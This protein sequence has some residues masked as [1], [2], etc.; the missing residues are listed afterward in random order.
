MNALV[1]LRRRD[2][3]ATVVIGLYVYHVGA[4]KE[5]RVQSKVWRRDAQRMHQRSKYQ[6]TKFSTMLSMI[7]VMVVLTSIKVKSPRELRLMVM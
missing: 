3:I 4:V 7:V 5:V 2:T 1:A 6:L